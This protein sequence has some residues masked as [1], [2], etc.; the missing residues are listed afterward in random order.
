MCSA[1]AWRLGYPVAPESD[2]FP[3]SFTKDRTGVEVGCPK[4]C[5]LWQTFSVS[6]KDQPT[7][8]PTLTFPLYPVF[9]RQKEGVWC[10]FVTCLYR[11][12]KAFSFGIAFCKEN[13]LCYFSTEPC[14]DFDTREE[15]N[16][17]TDC[18]F[19]LFSEMAGG[20]SGAVDETSPSVLNSG[21]SAGFPVS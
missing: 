10:S 14:V 2:Q 20:H 13:F 3:C 8:T 18:S 19:R 4:S 15:Q 11:P 16:L 9:A 17:D 5:W 1:I 21:R 6:F 7:L 12:L